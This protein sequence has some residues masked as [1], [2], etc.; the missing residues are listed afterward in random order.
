MLTFRADPAQLAEALGEE[1]SSVLGETP[2]AIPVITQETT[3]ET[4]QEVSSETVQGKILALLRQHPTMTRREL[5]TQFGLSTDG[6]KY[7]LNKLRAAGVIRH[8]GPT[9]NGR[10]EVLK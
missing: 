2:A 6:I 8:V 7:H 5:A 9:K 1:I 10:W 4:T 3:Q